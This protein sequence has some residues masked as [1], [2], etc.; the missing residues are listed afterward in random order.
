MPRRILTVMVIR[1]AITP[2]LNAS[3][4]PLLMNGSDTV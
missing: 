2:S 3:R 1:M 4:R